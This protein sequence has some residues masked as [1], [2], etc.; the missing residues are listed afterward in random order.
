MPCYEFCKTCKYGGD[1]TINNCTS[2]AF[3]FIFIPGLINTTN[4][5]IKCPYFYYYTT[6][7]Q[8]KCSEL[9]VCPED[10][11]LLI[12]NKEQCI[13]DCKKDDEY[14]YQYNGECYKEC[15]SDSSD[16]EDFICK[17]NNINIFQ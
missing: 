13:E 3:G 15:P 2:C 6:Y 5:V 1:N 9:S 8:Y 10:Y 7:G 12:R 17:D 11:N 16:N 14:K 4:C